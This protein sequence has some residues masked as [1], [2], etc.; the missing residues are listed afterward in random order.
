M[1][2]FQLANPLQR[3]WL[4]A[5]SLQTCEGFGTLEASFVVSERQGEMPA[6]K[7]ERRER[8]DEW[9]N[10]KQWALCPE[11]EQYEAIRPLVLFH[12][13]A[14]WSKRNGQ[15]L[16]G[17][18]P[19]AHCRSSRRDAHHVSREKLPRCATSSMG[20]AQILRTSNVSRPLASAPL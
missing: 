5:L 6:P 3:A 4:A 2:V 9:A 7:R 20:D 13:T 11:Q 16:A 8:T 14:G 10:I 19:P 12:E 17:R 15:D 18:R 1:T